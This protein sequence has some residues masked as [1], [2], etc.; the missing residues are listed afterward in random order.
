[1]N[2]LA[3]CHFVE[4]ANWQWFIRENANRAMTRDVWGR[5]LFAYG[6]L[7]SFRGDAGHCL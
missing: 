4:I 7:A 1:M 3:V 5:S 2:I 6:G